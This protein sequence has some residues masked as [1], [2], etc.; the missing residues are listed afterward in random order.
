M[1]FEGALEDA[2]KKLAKNSKKT[3][4]AE[5]SFKEAEENKELEK[6]RC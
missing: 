4:A 3:K 5:R 6:G 2:K 1:E